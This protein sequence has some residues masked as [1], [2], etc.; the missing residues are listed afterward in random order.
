MNTLFNQVLPRSQVGFHF[1]KNKISTSVTPLQ[2]KIILVALTAIV[3]AVNCI[4]FYRYC[5]L[6]DKALKREEIRVELNNNNGNKVEDKKVEE[7]KVEE[8]KI[9]QTISQKLEKNKKYAQTQQAQE[10]A[11][12]FLIEGGDIPFF[13]SYSQFFIREFQVEWLDGSGRVAEIAS[14]QGRRDSMEDADIVTS[15]SFKVLEKDY[16]FDIFGVFDGHGG[17]N[18]SA[19]AKDNIAKY[20]KDALESHNPET[21]TEEGVFKALKACF[22]KLDADYPDEK[23]EGTTAT[24]AIILDGK[25]WVANVGD[26]RTIFVKDGKATQAS[27][28]AKP[29]MDRYKKTIEKLGGFVAFNGVFR[30]NGN[31]GVARAIG[32]KGI[33]GKEGKCCVSPNP[34]I[35]CFSLEDYRNGCLVLACDGLWDVSTTDEVGKAITQMVANNESEGMMSKRLVHNAIRCGSTD[36]VSVVVVKL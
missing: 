15:Q 17:A 30:V 23:L 36:N 2:Q 10:T 31:L 27:E 4:I 26:S 32:D 19:F 7:S 6:K 9:P 21:L 11:K 18:A 25:I 12:G 22:Q 33:K 13:P 1:I 34:K 8:K 5:Y 24:V 20:L 16:S 3:V 14:S 29:L 28:D 35:C